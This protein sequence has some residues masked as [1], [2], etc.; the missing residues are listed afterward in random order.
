V[1]VNGKFGEALS[2]NG[3][4]YA[5]VPSS[6]SL[7]TSEEITIDAW[8]NVQS[9]KNITYNNIF[10]E[11]V[12]TTTPLPTRTLGLAING[13][14]PENA[15]FPPQG[16]LR[17]YV[18]TETGLKEIVTKESVPLNKWLHV[19]FTHSLTSGMLIYVDGQEK[20]VQ[21]TS[22]IANPDGPIVR[23]NEIY[24]GHDSIT[25]IDQLQISNMI[26]AQKQPL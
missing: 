20:Q 5:T 10:V 14:T 26:E 7:Q 12:R 13:E 24:V 3:Q 9:I 11:C 17:A 2:F 22:G 16:A 4:Y 8:I 15:S 6:P 19:V 21:V 23:Q 1:Q 25:Y 18:L